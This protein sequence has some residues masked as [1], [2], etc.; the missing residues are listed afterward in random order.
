VT[1]SNTIASVGA[2]VSNV[3]RDATWFVEETRSPALDGDIW[4][5]MRQEYRFGQLRVLEETLAMLLRET[6][7]HHVLVGRQ[8]ADNYDPMDTVR[9]PLLSGTA[10]GYVVTNG[11]IAG[12]W[13]RTNWPAWLTVTQAFS[14][15]GALTNN[16]SFSHPN[17]GAYLTYLNSVT[18][19]Y[20]TTNHLAEVARALNQC[21]YTANTNPA[22]SALGDANQYV[23]QGQ[24]TSS[25]A[26]AVAAAVAAT[27]TIETNDA[28]PYA[29][30]EGIGQATAPIYNTT[31]W[32][33]RAYSRRAVLIETGRCEEVEHAFD[34]YA[35]TVPPEDTGYDTLTFDLYGHDGAEGVLYR[36]DTTGDT[37]AGGATSEW[38]S[39]VT[40][41]AANTT[42]WSAQPDP[43]DAVGGVTDTARGFTVDAGGTIMRWKFTRLGAGA[44]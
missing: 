35:R 8:H 30:T 34:F 27:P 17:T 19:F 14:N 28:A 5:S 15:A 22:W 4:S 23:W 3:T 9:S 21:A 12:E 37:W 33:A 39:A 36:F 1:R 16:F 44:P 38:H 7:R 24:S 43:P 32:T 18:N 41:P 40:I 31:T 25:W 13:T 10:S 26:A 20:L 11:F 42:D 6:R 29:W 2:A